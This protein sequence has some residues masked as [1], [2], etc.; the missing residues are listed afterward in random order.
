MFWLIETPDQ[1]E[2]FKAKRLQKLFAA[3]IDRHPEQHPGIY[4]PLAIYVKALETGER[5]VIN[6]S[7]PDSFNVD[8]LSLKEFLQTKDLVL[9]LLDRKNFNYLVY[10]KDTLDCRL[11]TKELISQY[12]S[13]LNADLTLEDPGEVL[14]LVKHVEILDK[15][16]ET[17][18]D[19]ILRTQLD[20]KHNE[21]TDI[22]W[23]IERN[24]IKVTDTFNEVFDVQRP[25]LSRFN[26]YVMSHY[27]LDTATGRPSNTF[28][29]INLAA[30]PKG[31][32]ERE[33]LIPRND[34]L[35]QIDIKSFH[36]TLMAKTIGYQ[37]KTK[38]L[39]QDLAETYNISREEAKATAFK[40][41][42]GDTQGKFRDFEFF[43]EIGKLIQ[44]IWLE[45]LKK[46]YISFPGTTKTFYVRE[47]P[48]LHATKLF[49]YIYQSLETGV[50]LDIVKEV[51]RTLKGRDSV[52][53]LY[54]YDAIVLDMTVEDLELLPAIKREYQKKGFEVEISYG[55]NYNNLA[56]Y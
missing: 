50:H 33:C 48:D 43:K 53:I 45:F 9:Y 39:Y 20:K 31:S 36:P 7:H 28:N 6:L 17:N 15:F 41:L 2:R 32:A 52:I 8:Y 56:Q 5:F 26:T 38:D 42:Y 54:V 37:F 19:K 4:T 14:P 30:L 24:G 44:T 46:S 40:Y 18:Q 3:T 21:R 35:V 13:Y 49:N 11:S 22:L 29:K 1:F 10:R 23:L 16:Y 27:N 55:K 34:Y 12:H 25:F 51:F 47:T